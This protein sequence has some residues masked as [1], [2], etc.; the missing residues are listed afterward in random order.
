LLDAQALV[1]ELVPPGSVFAF[2]AE[3][4]H[5]LFPDSFIADLFKSKTGRPSLPADLVGSVRFHRPRTDTPH[6]HT[7]GDVARSGAGTGAGHSA[8]AVLTGP[9]SALAS[10]SVARWR[11]ASS[12]AA[13]PDPAAVT[14]CR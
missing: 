3:H 11:S 9:A 7:G 12:A 13:Q 14:A 8:A 5:E 2:L 10:S 6:P 1:G 4:R